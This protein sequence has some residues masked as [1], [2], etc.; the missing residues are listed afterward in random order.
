MA[1]IADVTS[2][3][4]NDSI[5]LQKAP[6]RCDVGAALIIEMFRYIQRSIFFISQ[7][8]DPAVLRPGLKPIVAST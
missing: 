5:H 7:P 8:N 1:S 6:P 3:N 4:A 2:V